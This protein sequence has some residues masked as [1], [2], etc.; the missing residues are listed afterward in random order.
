M[1]LDCSLENV[2][3]FLVFYIITGP[4]VD[5]TLTPLCP[6][7]SQTT[8]K[9]CI[10]SLGVPFLCLAT[11][12]AILVQPIN[13]SISCM[14]WPLS[15]PHPHQ[16]VLCNVFHT[17]LFSTGGCGSAPVPRINLIE[18]TS[19]DR[20]KTNSLL[21]CLFGFWSRTCTLHVIYKLI[22]P[23]NLWRQGKDVDGSFVEFWWGLSRFRWLNK[24]IWMILIFKQKCRGFR[25]SCCRQEPGGGDPVGRNDTGF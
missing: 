13:Q 12:T 5:L 25:F 2:V 10:P 4:S 1:L 7:S 22:E 6:K 21:I 3:A 18:P 15:S 23:T 20:Q 19:G 16:K 9:E 11:V 17:S 14:Y 8:L 24:G